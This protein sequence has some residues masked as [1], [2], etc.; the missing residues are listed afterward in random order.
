MLTPSDRR[1]GQVREAGMR[2]T[3]L[4]IRKVLLAQIATGL[5]CDLL[6]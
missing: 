4:Q 6:Q 2:V 5:L 1:E 3:R